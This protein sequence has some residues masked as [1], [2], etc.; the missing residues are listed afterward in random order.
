MNDEELTQEHKTIQA[1]QTLK[2]TP[3]R[4]ADQAALGRQAFL[5]QAQQI[6]KQTVSISPFQRLIN[7]FSQPKPQLRFSTL[8]IAIFL[9]VLLLTFSSSAYAARQSKPDQ[10]LYP[11]KLWLENS[12]LSL[13]RQTDRQID[14]HLVFAEERLKELSTDAGVYSSSGIDQAMQNLSS[15]LEALRDLVGAD[16]DDH[17][18]QERLE[19][20]QEKYE[21]IEKQKDDDRREDQK[22]DDSPD[23]DKE[24]EEEQKDNPDEGDDERKENEE[25]ED[26]SHSN[27]GKNSEDNIDNSDDDKPDQPSDDS[28]ADDEPDPTDEPDEDPTNEPDSSDDNDPTKTPKPD[29]DD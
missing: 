23:S 3:P 25:S 2:E 22:E 5:A 18:Q 28:D 1:L 12:R 6:S 8:T 26:D 11:F 14:L 27:S 20:I 21:E 16:Q 7:V 9:S 29:D 13:T 19:A 17:S 24:Q 10:I 4:D 15:H